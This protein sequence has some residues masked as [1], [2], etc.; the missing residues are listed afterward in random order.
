MIKAIILYTCLALSMAS[1][2][3]GMINVSKNTVKKLLLNYGL[4]HFVEKTNIISRLSGKKFPGG[5]HM[6]IQL[7]MYD[8][9]K[10]LEG[11]P[12]AKVLLLQTKMTLDEIV[13]KLLNEFGNED[14][15]KEYES[16]EKKLNKMNP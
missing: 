7:S 12:M 11:N 9:A 4:N 6:G 15:I 10:N 3:E 16:I 2:C 8:Y 14:I 13:K 1:P 5:I